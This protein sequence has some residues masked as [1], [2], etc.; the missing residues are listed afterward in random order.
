MAQTEL[1]IN[2]FSSLDFTESEASE[3]QILD[4]ILSD[5]VSAK[6][7]D[8][9]KLEKEK[10]EDKTK[11]KEKPLDKTKE[12]LE[13][14]AQDALD[15]ALNEDEE[16]G[17]KEED[18]KPISKKKEEIKPVEENDDTFSLLSK[19]LF[20]LGVF[21]KDEDEEDLKIDTPEK[22]LD[23]FVYETEKKS[24]EKIE[25]FLGKF[26]EDYKN[27]FKSIFV[28]GV[29]PKEYFISYNEIV[30][31]ANL[32]LK[33]ESNQEEVVKKELLERGYTSDQIKIKL[34]RFK[35]NGELEEEATHS[36]SVLLKNQTAKLAEK[37]ERSR[38]VQSQQIAIKQ[39]F[40][41][42]VSKTLEDKLKTKE[43][44]G[45]PLN[46]KIAQELQDYLITDKWRTSQG[47]PLTDFDKFI[48]DLKRP[49]NH[50]LKV[51]FALLVK[52][53]EKDPTLKTIQRTGVTKEAN[54]L[55]SDLTIKKDKSSIREQKTTFANYL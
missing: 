55:F 20:D 40:I 15:S 29:D 9:Q 14:E 30:D 6:P 47:E 45:I 19:N 42:N 39:Q 1:D 38:A 28:D 27:A 53:L 31:L 24:N 41:N 48:L 13:K 22:F 21:S 4:D 3:K 32:D 25:T 37:E 46:P 51:K 2:P 12:Q 5:T 44:D 52:T 43:F 17:S 26:G 7:E 54:K 36:H 33:N 18:Q 8:V 11:V 35:N 49:E 50:T 34:E 16:E 10:S 23:R